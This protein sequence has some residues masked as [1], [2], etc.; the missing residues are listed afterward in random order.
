MAKRKTRRQV[1]KSPDLMPPGEW[2]KRS[3]V[4]VD[5]D[6]LTA[7]AL[8][9]SREE[10][11]RLSGRTTL[12]YIVTTYRIEGEWRYEVEFHGE[13][14][15]MPGKVVD[16][17]LKHREAI[18]AE[19]ASQRAYDTHHRLKAKA[20]EETLENQ[21]RTVLSHD[22]VSIVNPGSEGMAIERTYAPYRAHR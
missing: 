10:T 16:A 21:E 1:R 2:R 6:G 5:Y 20:Q 15:R 7:A 9:F 8:G 14:W 19:Q 4:S 18:K 11:E 12:N 17:M 3:L 22:T 13:R